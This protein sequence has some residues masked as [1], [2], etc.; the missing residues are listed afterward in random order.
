MLEKR[1]WCSLSGDDGLD[2]KY[3]KRESCIK[4]KDAEGSET[5]L[6]REPGEG[7]LYLF[8]NGQRK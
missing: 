4:F 7:T 1:K 3:V 6:R 2:E 8:Y 5:F